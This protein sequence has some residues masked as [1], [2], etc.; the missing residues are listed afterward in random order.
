MLQ[1]RRWI[2]VRDEWR[3]G[4]PRPFLT[5][6]KL[7]LDRFEFPS[8]LQTPSVA[9]KGPMTCQDLMWTQALALRAAK[10]RPV[11]IGMERL[12]TKGLTQSHVWP[13]RKAPEL[14]E[15]FEHRSPPLPRLA[16]QV[17]EHESGIDSA[18]SSHA[19]SASAI[20]FHVLR[21]REPQGAGHARDATAHVPSGAFRAPLRL[22]LVFNPAQRD[23]FRTTDRPYARHASMSSE[24]GYPP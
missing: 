6:G 20:D 4:E 1:H 7:V 16:R 18:A 10:A 19:A 9:G 23:W 15:S 13:Q 2:A 17:G 21:H 22:A 12:A 11:V 24:I 8:A 5:A 3:T 14:C